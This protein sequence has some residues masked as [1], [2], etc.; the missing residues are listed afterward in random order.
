M[1][2][3][4]AAQA[5]GETEAEIRGRWGRSVVVMNNSDSRIVP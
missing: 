3:G 1:F 5:D 4:L 2:R